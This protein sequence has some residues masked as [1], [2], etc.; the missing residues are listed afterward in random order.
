MGNVDLLRQP[1]VVTPGPS[2]P[3][4]VELRDDTAELEGTATGIEPTSAGPAFLGNRPQV[5]IYCI[6]LPDSPGQFNQTVIEQS[7]FHNPMMAPGDYRILAF[8]SRQLHLPYRDAEAMK[9]YETRGPVV[10]LAAGQKVNVQ[11]PL[12]TDSDEPEQ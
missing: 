1:L 10:H 5:W 2:A 12:I 3:I 6:P 11:V 9:V 4:E 7:E 8:A